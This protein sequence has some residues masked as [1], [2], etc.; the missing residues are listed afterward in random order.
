MRV[1]GGRLRGRALAG[2]KS[3]A[4]RP[5]ADRLCESLFN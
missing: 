1:V 5:A 3:S 2:P 4:I